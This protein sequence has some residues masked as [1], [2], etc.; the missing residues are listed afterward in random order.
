MGIKDNKALINTPADKQ[1]PFLIGKNWRPE[2]S[3]PRN[4]LFVWQCVNRLL[5]ITL[6]YHLNGIRT[7]ENVICAYQQVSSE[8]RNTRA[9]TEL[10]HQATLSG[11]VPLPVNELAVTVSKV[12]FGDMCTFSASQLQTSSYNE[13]EHIWT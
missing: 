13:M 9:K 7:R 5:Y 1:Y 6:C 10:C 3:Q 2:N 8:A 12:I 11:A 4:V